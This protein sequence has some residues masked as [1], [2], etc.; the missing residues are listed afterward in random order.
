VVAVVVL[1]LREP[2]EQA[3]QVAVETVETAQMPPLQE[4]LIRVVAVVEHLII[5]QA[6][7]AA[8]VSSLSNTK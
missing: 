8:P 7:Q 2:P 5:K 4:P 3:A 1:I 6:A